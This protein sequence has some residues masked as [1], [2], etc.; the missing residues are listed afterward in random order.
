ME[1]RDCYEIL[2][3]YKC[4]LNCLFCSQ[5]GYDR[6][7]Y[8]S[9]NDIAKEIYKAKK[10]GYRKLGISGGEPTVRND[11]IEII[12]FAK[13]AG[14]NFI[15][16]QTNG[17]RLSDFNFA[18]KL[19]E[20]GLT[21][22]KFSITSDNPQ[23][24][25]MLTGMKNGYEKVM[26]ALDNM[27]KLK[28]RTGNNILINKYNYNRLPD[29]IEFLL[30]KGISNFVIIY[31]VYT[32]NMYSNYKK[33]GI[34]L[35]KCK[36]YFLRAIEIMSENNMSNEILFLNVP[37]CFLEGYEEN[38]I[39]ISEFNTV[40][41]SPDMDLINL[42]DRTNSNKIKGVICRECALRVKC[43]GV[44]REY[45][46]LFGWKDFKPLDKKR[47][48]RKIYFSD[49]EKCLIEIL[50]NNKKDMTV[51][52]IIKASKKIPLCQN[53]QDANNIINA[54]TTLSVKKIVNIN[55]KNGKYYFSLL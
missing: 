14:F 39:G 22:C 6:A 20:A 16:I 41:K 26:K 36:K 7:L 44:D 38:L 19:K 4:N 47:K 17:I 33:L 35:G 48:K 15:R 23:I 18:K 25:N 49:D 21:F 13:K 43:S 28:I 9:Y 29:I 40:V 42:D 31:P 32:G 46:K 11:L 8:M 2:L 55:F 12:K 24:H 5:G 10:M 3:N 54:A 27:K 45:I 1:K 51:E 37:P 50:K 53:C 52:K 34:E 30:E